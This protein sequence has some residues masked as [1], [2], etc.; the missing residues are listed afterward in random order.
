MPAV[1]PQISHLSLEYLSVPFSS[2]VDPATLNGA[3][4]AFTRS[5]TDDPDV[6]HT[7]TIAGSAV[8]LLV[9]PGG[10]E[11]L[12]EGTWVVWVK[13]TDAPEVTVEAAGKVIVF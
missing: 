13:L 3:E 4:M 7:A 5:V 1:I 6:W 9:G 11:Q 2:D 8:Q 12:A 10:A